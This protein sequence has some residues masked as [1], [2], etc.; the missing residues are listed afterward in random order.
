MKAVAVS[1]GL[2]GLVL[3]LSCA[4]PC[5]EGSPPAGRFVNATVTRTLDSKGNRAEG[6]VKVTDP[7]E[8]AELASFYPCVGTGRSSLVAAG[9]KSRVTTVFERPD[10]KTVTAYSDYEDWSEG[11]G[12][13]RVKRGFGEYVDRLFAER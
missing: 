2:L 10:G 4:S 6:R 11:K 5:L 7:T 8:V 9:Y 13:F 1:L 3:S 12:D